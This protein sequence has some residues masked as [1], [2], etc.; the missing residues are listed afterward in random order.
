MPNNK[1]PVRLTSTEDPST[2]AARGELM[3]DTASSRLT[4]PEQELTILLNE[5][6][7]DEAEQ[8][9][10]QLWQQRCD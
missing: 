10:T 1:E 2:A 3:P 5:G 7:Q 9:A 6:R 8:L 4:Q